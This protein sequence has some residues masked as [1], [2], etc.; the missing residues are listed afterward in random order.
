MVLAG[1]VDSQAVADLL[2]SWYLPN[3]PPFRLGW[4]GD[5][6]GLLT[7]ATWWYAEVVAAIA[8]AATT[9]RFAL[10]VTSIAVEHD[11]WSSVLAEMAEGC[12]VA[13][14]GPRGSSW[15]TYRRGD[16]T[17]FEVDASATCPR[18]MCV[19]VGQLLIPPQ[20]KTKKRL[21]KALGRGRE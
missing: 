9:R 12:V 8:H 1:A 16:W 17:Q 19:T 6:E 15:W 3:S 20:A 5:R 10:Q 18:D 2:H 14:F 13:T 11:L 4:W 21:E 7:K